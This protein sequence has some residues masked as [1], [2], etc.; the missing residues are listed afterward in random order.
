LVHGAGCSI[1]NE[2]ATLL[3]AQKVR[4]ILY[5]DVEREQ[6]C[7]A[8]AAALSASGC[9]VD[10]LPAALSNSELVEH[11]V[12]LHGR[13]D[14]LFNLMVPGVG[15]PVDFVFD[16][17]RLLLERNMAAAEAMVSCGS[18]G[19]IV[20]QCFLGSLF[21]G[22]SFEAAIVMAKGAITGLTRELCCKFGKAGLRINTIQLGLIDLPETKN[23]VTEKT[24]ARKTPVGRWAAPV[25][26]AKFMAFLAL[27]NGYMTGQA[28]C[29]DGGLTAGNTGT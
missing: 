15:T 19:A 23:L 12:K 29:F 9:Q 25:E 4:L 7:Q 22:T 27:R 13:L 18:A 14:C 8:T 28:I 26:P 24:S 17:P 3:H 5:D 20:N 21:Q 1:G 16:Y 2:L 10:V 11:A 6:A